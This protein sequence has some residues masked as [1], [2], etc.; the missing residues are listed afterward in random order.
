MTTE[1]FNLRPLLPHLVQQF[2]QKVAGHAF[3][4]KRCSKYA[5]APQSS[6]SEER[7]VLPQ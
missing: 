7:H 4:Q 6:L 3:N 5:T 1:P 2:E